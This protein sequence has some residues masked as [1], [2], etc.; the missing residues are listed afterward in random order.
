MIAVQRDRT[1]EAGA[2]VAPSAVWFSTAHSRRLSAEQE[3]G[4]HVVDRNV[5]A[6]PEVQ[7]ALE[8]LFFD[9][10]AYCEGKPVATGDWDVEHFRPKGRV[11]ERDGHPGYYWLAYEWTNLYLSCQHCNQK[12]ADRA[13]WGD[14]S[15]AAGP[16]AGKLDQFP[17]FDETTRALAHGDDVRLETP[18]LLDPCRD[19]PERH[20]RFSPLGDA[21]AVDGS[22]R[23]DVSIQVF[24]LRR[25]R[26]KDRRRE[27][28][29]RVVTALRRIEELKVFVE[30]LEPVA[31][32]V[33]R[34]HVVAAF[35][36]F[37]ANFLADSCDYAA[38][39]RWVLRDPTSFGL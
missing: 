21:L 22:R 24:H 7:R 12:R 29:E 13:R 15:L 14:T 37:H 38:A 35:D 25:K 39:G 34:A 32:E 31:A 26:L 20:I 18:L 17:L 16:A 27:R 1:D 30:S 5:Y 4:A 9:K 19:E 11:A 2:A 28:I 3:Q 23:G 8:K 36:D 10:C 33:G 6:A